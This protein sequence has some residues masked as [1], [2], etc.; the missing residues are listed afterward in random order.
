V[1]TET[2]AEAGTDIPAEV[3]GI[4]TSAASTLV[5]AAGIEILGVTHG[6]FPF[7]FM[8]LHRGDRRR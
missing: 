6:V 8:R 7:W 1:A 2:G 3:A 5:G 4:V